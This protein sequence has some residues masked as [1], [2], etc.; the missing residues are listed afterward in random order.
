MKWLK[1]AALIKLLLLLTVPWFFVGSSAEIFGLP[2]WTACA[3]AAVVLYPIVVSIL[4]RTWWDSMAN[5][6]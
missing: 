1:R 2:A 6:S 4:L 5:D 3:I